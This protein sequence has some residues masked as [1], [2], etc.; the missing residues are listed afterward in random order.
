MPP[1]SAAQARA[2]FAAAAGKSTLGIPA[3]VGAEFTSDQAPGSVKR[4][5][6]HVA[7]KRVGRLKK[8]A[9]SATARRRR[10]LARGFRLTSMQ[11]H[12]DRI[13]WLLRWQP[14]HSDASA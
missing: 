14:K 6:E 10:R 3:K 8:A 2:M 1:R 4:L 9:A 13:P 11:P 7:K 5:P 12:R